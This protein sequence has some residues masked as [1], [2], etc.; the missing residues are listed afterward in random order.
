MSYK[1]KNGEVVSEVAVITEYFRK[2]SET[3]KDFYEQLKK[4]SPADKTEL[5][6]GA[7]IELGYESVAA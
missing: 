5:A 1:K 3:V 2:P 6:N 4:L 7:A